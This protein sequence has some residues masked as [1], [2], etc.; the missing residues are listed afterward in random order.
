MYMY[1]GVTCSTKYKVEKQDTLYH[2]QVCVRTQIYSI[3][4][5][6]QNVHEHVLELKLPHPP[7]MDQ[8]FQQF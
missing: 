4:V 5:H 1:V 7:T 8:A 3:P 6:T 2:V